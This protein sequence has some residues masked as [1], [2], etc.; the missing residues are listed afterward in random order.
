MVKYSYNRSK[1]DRCVYLRGLNYGYFIYLLLYVD[2]MLIGV[3]NKFEINKL[4]KLL[5]REFEM[6]DLGVEKKILNMGFVEIEKL[7]SCF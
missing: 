1:Y 5:S 6:K 4:K 7:V 3:K 2:D